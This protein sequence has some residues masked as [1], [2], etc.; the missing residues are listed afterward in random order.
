MLILLSI[1]GSAPPAP[2]EGP[3]ERDVVI[4]F[5]GR[6]CVECHNNDEKAAGLDLE[7]RVPS[8]VAMTPEVWE[9]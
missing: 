3:D 4:R 5:V 9:R 2:A 8:D 7:A 1:C 6:Y